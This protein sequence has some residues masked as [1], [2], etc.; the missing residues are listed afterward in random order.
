MNKKRW[1]AGVPR[2]A[3]VKTWERGRRDDG[4]TLTVSVGCFLGSASIHLLLFS[5]IFLSVDRRIDA[6]FD[7]SDKAKRRET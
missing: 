3:A 6:W 5:R 2:T 1:F 4:E 7:P